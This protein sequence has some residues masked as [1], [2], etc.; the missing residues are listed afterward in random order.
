MKQTRPT[1]LEKVDTFSSIV[2]GHFYWNCSIFWPDKGIKGFKLN[3]KLKLLVAVCNLFWSC[4]DPRNLNDR[5]LFLFASWR[6]Y[7]GLEEFE[8]PCMGKSRPRDKN[9]ILCSWGPVP[10]GPAITRLSSCYKL[11]PTKFLLNHQ[12]Y[13]SNTWKKIHFAFYAQC[14]LL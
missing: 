12:W 5:K 7:C 10:T 11:F 14:F 9:S 6:N 3:F 2:R 4:I 1:V 8:P 13:T